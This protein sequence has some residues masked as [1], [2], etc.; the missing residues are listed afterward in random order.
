MYTYIYINNNNNNINI[1]ININI[2][3]KDNNNSSNN[4]NNSNN[5]KKKKKKNN[6]NTNSINNYL[7]NAGFL[8]KWL[9]IWQIVVIL[10][11]INSA[12]NK[13]GRIRQVAFRRVVPPKGRRVRLVPGRRHQRRRHTAAAERRDL[14][15]DEA[16]GVRGNHLSYTTCLTHAFFKS[17]E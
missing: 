15:G 1:N 9:A 10:D 4:S 3:N 8:Q 14:P 12:Y 6:N 2:N 5:N 17:G 16:R 13:R 11:T 7:S